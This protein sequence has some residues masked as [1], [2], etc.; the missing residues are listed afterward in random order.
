MRVR[1]T[2][3]VIATLGAVTPS[4]FAQKTSESEEVLPVFAVVSVKRSTGDLSGRLNSSTILTG[5]P[6][7]LVI[8]NMTVRG[9]IRNAYGIF[10]PKRND[11]IGGPGWID[12]ERWDVEAIVE[13][14]QA[15]ARKLLMLRRL[16]VERFKLLIHREARRQETFVLVMDQRD[17]KPGPGLRNAPP[18]TRAPG[19]NASAPNERP[20][21]GRGG[22]GR[23]VGTGL[24]M[25]RLA[26]LLTSAASRPVTD[27]TGLS[28]TFDV[29]LAW[30]QELSIFTALKEQ[31]GL[32]L[33]NGPAVTEDSIVIDRVERPSEN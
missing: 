24:T 2:V 21:G 25:P 13:G 31:L 4:L 14:D 20:C 6:G 22:A 16:L 28:G 5:Q 3:A 7:R 8:T 18:C 10:I 19:A 1:T 17:G 29:D 11:V 23:I 26:D 27:Q 15:Q 30:S 9:I 33:D 12:D 32:R